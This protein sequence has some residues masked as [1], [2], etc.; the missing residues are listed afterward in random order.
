[1][2]KYEFIKIVIDFNY[3]WILRVDAE[4]LSNNFFTNSSKF[5]R[6]YFDFKKYK[7]YWKFYQN[8]IIL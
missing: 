8:S 3:R 1:M 7:E 5:G 6:F 2:I 4:Y